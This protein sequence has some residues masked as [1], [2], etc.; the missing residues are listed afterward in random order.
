MTWFFLRAPRC[1][2]EPV[3]RRF[4]RKLS[5]VGRV[6]VTQLG[7]SA[8]PSAGWY[9]LS[10]SAKDVGELREELRKLGVSDQIDM[11]EVLTHRAQGA[12]F[13]RQ[14]PLFS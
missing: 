14:L 5:R 11:V 9:V 12:T 13:A 10:A 6:Y 8:D 7:T 1:G 2:S 4:R 3:V